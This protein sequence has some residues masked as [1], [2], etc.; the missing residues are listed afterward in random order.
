VTIIALGTLVIRELLQQRVFSNRL[1]RR[2]LLGRDFVEGAWV[3]VVWLSDGTRQLGKTH[4]GPTGDGLKFSGTNY[5]E[6]GAL[7]GGFSTTAAALDGLELAYVCRTTTHEATPLHGNAAGGL[8]FE[9][10]DGE[11]NSYIGWFVDDAGSVRGSFRGVK[12]E[13]RYIGPLDDESTRHATLLQLTAGLRAMPAPA[14]P[15]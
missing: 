9:R 5:D 8:Q 1:V 14:R 4:V 7:V 13:R 6:G 3:D 10:V 15:T 2:A 12:V 11:A